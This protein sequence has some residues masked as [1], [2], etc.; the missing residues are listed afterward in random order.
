MKRYKSGLY[1]LSNSWDLA[2]YHEK[3]AELVKDGH[4]KITTYASNIKN[5]VY[6]ISYK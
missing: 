6:I 3:I 5:Y 1:N 2:R 4:I